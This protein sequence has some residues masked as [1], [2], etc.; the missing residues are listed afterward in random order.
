MRSDGVLLLNLG[1]PESPEPT[2]VGRYLREFLMDP[3]V[4]D[5]PWLVRWPLVNLAIVPRRSVSS[6]ALYRKIWTDRGSPLLFHT[7]DLAQAVGAMLGEGVPVRAAMRYGPPGIARGLKELAD[8]RR[9]AVLPLYPQYS[10]AATESSI[11]YVTRVAARLGIGAE[12]RF[13]PAFYDRAPYLDAV[14]EVSRAHLAR[15]HDAVLF[16]FHGLPARQIRRATRT[17]P[18]RCYRTQCFATA[19]ALAVRLGVPEEKYHVGFQSRMA[20]T[21]W[22]QPYSDAHYRELPA[23]GIRRIAVLCPS[24]VADCLETLEEVSLRGLEEFRHHGGEDLF[25]VPSL[26]AEPVWADAVAGFARELLSP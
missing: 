12:L 7:L 14:A 8:C 17:D 13:L 4:I 11:G 10:L 24:F 23:R 22:I 21:P 6:A 3:H 15:P 19:R 9:I 26:N 5:V 25:L 20:G 18:T 2:A 1:T 16:S